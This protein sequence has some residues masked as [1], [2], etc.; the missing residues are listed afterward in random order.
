M[1]P[2]SHQNL[3][4][5]GAEF[6]VMHCSQHD[7]ADST[8]G[9]GFRRRRKTEHHGAE[10]DEDQDRGGNDAEQALSPQR[11]A[12]QRQRS[13]R[14]RWQMVRLDDAK[15]EG[16]AGEQ[17]DLKN[18]RSP[19]AEVHVA[20]RLAEL[21]GQH[22]QHQRRRHK[23]RDGTGGRQHAG[24]VAH[25]VAVADHHWHRDH[26]HGDDLRRHRPGDRPENEADEDDRV[27]EAAADRSKQLPHRI[28]H[29]FGQT[30]SFEDGA[31]ERE[32][33]NRQQQ[34]VRKHAAEHP[35]WNGLE[36]IH[37]EE[38]EMDGKEAE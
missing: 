24:D 14:Y 22:D 21:I 28:Q 25:I 38:A 8:H 5:G 10:H 16:V 32:E 35:A 18:R 23:L 1:V 26:R 31:H 13:L 29:V 34:F 30:A 4:A 19:G 27:A 6:L 15:H 7:C 9:A 11:P 33:W 12:G 36:K 37:V 3:V 17:K 2:T 20:D